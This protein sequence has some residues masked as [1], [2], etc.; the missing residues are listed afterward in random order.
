[1]VEQQKNKGLILIEA[2]RFIVRVLPRSMRVKAARN[3]LLIFINSLIELIGVAFLVP[4]LVVILDESKIF[5]NPW[6]SEA[7]RLGGFNSTTSFVVSLC[8]AIL[9]FI[10]AKN[11]VSLQLLKSQYKFSFTIYTFVSKQLFNYYYHQGLHEIKNV[12]SNRL[13]N[14]LNSVTLLF[15][16]Y[17]VISVMGII[18]ETL[19]VLLFIIGLLLY[20]PKVILLVA[21]LILP[22]LL[23]FFKLVRN[24]LQFLGKERNRISIEQHKVLYETFQGYPDIEVR[25]KFRWSFD[26]FAHTLAEMNKVQVKTTLL[27]QFPIKVIEVAIVSSLVVIISFCLYLG[28][29]LAEIGSLVG[30]FAVAAYRLLPGINRLMNYFM[31]LRNHIYSF[32]VVSKIIPLRNTDPDAYS[33]AVAENS[34]ELVFKDKIS[35]QN[36]SFSYDQHAVVLNNISFDIRKGDI[37]GIIG[38]SGSGKSTLLNVLLR[39]FSEVEGSVQVDGVRITK[40]NQ[41]A[42]RSLIGYVPQE[43]YV[44][45]ASLA[46]N[47]AL[48]ES[49]DEIDYEKL[50]NAI[51]RAHLTELVETLE[52]GVHTILNE[53]GGRLS[54]GQKQRLG[55]ARALYCGAQIL[56]LDE[57]TSALDVET[58]AEITTAIRELSTEDST[59]T[60]VIIAHRYATLKHCNRIIE[61][62]E[63]IV[64]EELTFDML[65]D[66]I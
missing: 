53:R 5:S 43:V 33:Q 37:L 18:S 34:G 52:D 10:I 48:G 25:N 21:I 1:M 55:I 20:D 36:I 29:S 30:V 23:L 56:F 41:S 32:D 40:E 42:W 8:I 11:I 9:L 22:S 54:G 6:L 19:V 44:F 16:Q 50:N 17:G 14:H 39:F 57:A 27:L 61:L 65:K 58:E 49:R 60:I 2:V 63:G 62:K 4:I 47:I 12:G 64:S 7:Y 3:L 35:I 59:L 28:K 15:T 31:T 51:R 26:R 13:V 46:E 38:R 45:D 66:R 24:K